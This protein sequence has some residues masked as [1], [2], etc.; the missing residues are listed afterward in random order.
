MQNNN[1]VKVVIAGGIYFNCCSSLPSFKENMRKGGL[2]TLS[3]HLHNRCSSDFLYV[4]TYYVV[5]PCDCLP[6]PTYI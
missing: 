2:K 6:M 4:H 5:L 1:E 3:Y